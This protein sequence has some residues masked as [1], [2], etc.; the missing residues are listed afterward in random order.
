[1][2]FFA[3]ACALPRPDQ[4]FIDDAAYTW[5]PWDYLAICHSELGMYEEALEETVRALRT[6]DDRRRLFSNVEFYLDQLR[7][8]NVKG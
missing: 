4:G 8:T 3:A 5:G 1:V 6:S 2:P 7:R